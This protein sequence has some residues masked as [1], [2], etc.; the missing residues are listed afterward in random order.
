MIHY[1]NFICSSSGICENPIFKHIMSYDIFARMFSQDPTSEKELFLYSCC[2][3]LL[4][5]SSYESFTKKRWI[6]FA[7]TTS[8]SALMVKSLL[9][10]LTTNYGLSVTLGCAALFALSS[11]FKYTIS[12]IISQAENIMERFEPFIIITRDPR[13][14]MLNQATTN[15][16]GN[17]NQGNLGAAA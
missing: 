16:V 11:A 3:P 5:A 10:E 15:A 13:E 14:A 4:A 17:L 12:L 6:Y 1:A 2:L 7:Y 9:E 8:V